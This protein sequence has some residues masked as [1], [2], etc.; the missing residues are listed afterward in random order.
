MLC[1][2]PLKEEI[3][4]KSQKT[5]PDNYKKL[6][7]INLQKDKKLA[8]IINAIAFLICAIMVAAMW[9]TY[10]IT[11]LFDMSDGLGLYII[12]FA[13]LVIGSIVYIILHE[14]VHGIFMKCFSGMK[15]KYGFT[16]M[17]AY[18]GS[19]AYFSKRDYIIIALAPIV[20]WGI[21]LAVINMIVPD[22]WFWV[23]YFI[24]IFNIS[25]AAGDIFVTAKFLKL[26]DDILVND[27]GY[28]MTVYKKEDE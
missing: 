13:V 28:E 22:S 20:I 5:L 26:P 14:L 23:V 10:S 17:Y 15:V 9:K 24:Q 21:V 12:R 8:L 16:G 6:Y 7:S 11:M 27:T 3:T 4:M 25:G 19:E 2:R 18:A 1:G